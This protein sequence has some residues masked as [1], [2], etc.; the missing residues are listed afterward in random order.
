MKNFSVFLMMVFTLQT[1]LFAAERPEVTETMRTVFNSLMNLQPFVFSLERFKD[2]KNKG[3][4]EKDLKVMSTLKH[5]FPKKMKDEEPGAAA[6]AGMFADY[7]NDVQKRFKNGDYDYARHRIKTVTGFCFGC[8]SRVGTSKNFEDMQRRIENL[9]LPAFEKAEFFAAT[10]QFDKALKIYG[11]FLETSPKSTMDAIQ[12]TRA[13]RHALNVT[14][15]VKG[16]VEETSKLMDPIS[17]RKDLPE[18]VQRFVTAWG[19]DIVAWKEEKV[20]TLTG[21]SLVEKARKLIERAQSLHSFPAD[22]NGD[23]SYL[24]ASNYLHEA[25]DSAPKAKYRGEALYLLG[26]AYDALQ[27]PMLWDL[28]R[29]YFESCVREFPKTDIAKQCFNRYANKV[30]IGY[31][32]SGGTFI[33]EDEAKKLEELKKFTQ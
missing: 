6:I 30:Y 11:D 16:S 17:K 4:I 29:L 3:I 15:R 8:H 18:F 23:I 14:V 33:P 1:S 20:E 28:D 2:P 32:G 26:L 19:K 27:D 25:L 12:F 22:E 9:G 10:R 21:E 5:A 13:L 24:R 31:T 7:L